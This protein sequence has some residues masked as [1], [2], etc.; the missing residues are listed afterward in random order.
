VHHWCALAEASSRRVGKGIGVR[1][2]DEDDDKAKGGREAKA[3][4]AR[5]RGLHPK[6]STAVARAYSCHNWIQNVVACLFDEKV[7]EGR[8]DESCRV[9]LL[10]ARA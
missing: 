5:A 7:E 4:S 10:L 2:Q 9:L 8:K 3:G 6:L 1:E